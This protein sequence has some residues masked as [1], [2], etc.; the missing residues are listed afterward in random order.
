MTTKTVTIKVT[1]EDIATAMPKDSGHCAIADAIARQ[2]PDAKSVTVDLQTIRW[3][4]A[5]HRY[6][7]LTPRKAQTFLV[8]YDQGLEEYC[9]PMS[10]R[11]TSPIHV[12]EKKQ[13][14]SV[15]AKARRVAQ[16]ERLAQLR[17]KR[18]RGEELTHAEKITISRADAKDA[19]DPT[20]ERPTT[21]G[22]VTQEYDA[23]GH[24]IVK[25]GV[26]PPLAA[27]AHGR[28]RRREFGMAVAGSPKPAP[29]VAD[30]S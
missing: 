6:T 9:Q 7:Y 8:A 13:S 5:T 22:P 3:S 14:N 1:E 11:L 28:G 12:G 21:Y 30:E 18:E 26:A 24:L 20:P 27:L 10:L 19:A 16:Q 23:D 29:R 15:K 4:D 17:A 25:G 2:I